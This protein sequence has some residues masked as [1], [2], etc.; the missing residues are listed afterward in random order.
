MNEIYKATS[1]NGR[2]GL[3]L[4]SEGIE[5]IRR[6]TP[7]RATAMELGEAERHRVVR[8]EPTNDPQ[9]AVVYDSDADPLSGASRIE[10][11]S[12]QGNSYA[13]LLLIGPKALVQ[14]WGYKRR[15]S[16]VIY[17]EQGE[18][19]R[20]PASVLLALGMLDSGAPPKTVPPPPPFLDEVHP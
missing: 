11:V 7:V 6:E 5:E 15:S 2:W 19:C 9:W 13:T 17:Y 16:R 3:A 18:E 20:V 10:S 8:L 14:V 4:V 12:L 1:Q